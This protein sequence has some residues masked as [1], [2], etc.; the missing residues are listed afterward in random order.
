MYSTVQCSAVNLVYIDY[1]MH[2]TGCSAV[3][4]VYG[5]ANILVIYDLAIF[6]LHS[7]KLANCFPP[8]SGHPVCNLESS[9]GRYNVFATPS[10]V[11]STVQCCQGCIY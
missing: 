6:W 3:N 4:V 11:Y 7:K 5:K 1:I 9:E 2:T 10:G 8:A